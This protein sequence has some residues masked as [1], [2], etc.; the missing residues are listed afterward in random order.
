MVA[1]CSSLPSVPTFKSKLSRDEP[2]Q[3]L[4]SPFTVPQ[5]PSQGGAGTGAHTSLPEASIN[6]QIKPHPTA[7]SRQGVKQVGAEPETC[8]AVTPCP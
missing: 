2:W 3:G 7:R 5:F 6:P 4:Q 8:P 1:A